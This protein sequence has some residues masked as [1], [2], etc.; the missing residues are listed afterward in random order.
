MVHV[1]FC[2]LYLFS[3]WDLEGQQ[4]PKG[5]CKC[6]NVR[7]LREKTR[8]RETDLGLYTVMKAE[9]RHETYIKRS[10]QTE[11]H[12]YTFDTVR[13][14]PSL[15][16]IT[17]KLDKYPLLPTAPYFRPSDRGIFLPKQHPWSMTTQRTNC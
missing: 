17:L 7:P 4:G 11:K 3:L 2:L 14:T 12:C 6:K 13:V 9:K 1:P 8:L 10:Q 5:P 16:T 15:H